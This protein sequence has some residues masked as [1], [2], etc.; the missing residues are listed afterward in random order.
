[1][2]RND[3]L[4]EL[5]KKQ[6]LILSIFR[7]FPQ[8]TILTPEEVKNLGTENLYTPA[9]WGAGRAPASAGRHKQGNE[10]YDLF[11][12]DFTRGGM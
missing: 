2:A 4:F 6:D 5:S 1:M 10:S 9:R 11:D 8:A 12:M 3:N 7:L